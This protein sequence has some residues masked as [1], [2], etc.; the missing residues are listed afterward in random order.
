MRRLALVI[1]VALLA[2]GVW[3]V[4]FHDPLAGLQPVR[5]ERETTASDIAVPSYPARSVDEYVGSAACRECHA[6][7]AAEYESH[8]MWH[9]TRAVSG[10]VEAAATGPESGFVFRGEQ[11]FV[12]NSDGE[13]VHHI[14]GRDKQ[15]E[16]LYDQSAHVSY[17]IGSGRRGRAFVLQQD[18]LLFQSPI[19]WYAGKDGWGLSPG[20]VASHRRFDRRLLDG[21]VNCHVGLVAGGSG[22]PDRF[23]SP[24]FIEEGVGC[25]RCHGPGAA[26][27]QWH[28]SQT[29]PTGPDPIVN[30][31]D[32]P[33]AEREAVCQQC[34][35]TGVER[36]VR[37]GR[38]EFDFRPGDRLSD[39]WMAF[40]LPGSGEGA[41][42][43]MAVSHVEELQTSRCWTEAAEPSDAPPVTIRTEFRRRTNGSASIAQNACNAME[44]RACHAVSRR[45]SVCSHNRTTPASP[46]TCRS[47][48]PTMCRTRPRPITGCCGI[49]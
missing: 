22:Q 26:H 23:A 5:N 8:P 29:A 41:G 1:V 34:H 18:D 2:G 35:L 12:E 10:P 25:E 44:N 21:C 4:F 36:V 13:A 39:V 47:W 46:A 32:L 31:V 19:T 3:L 45:H 30:P 42:K 17:E 20:Y 40:V 9:S 37:A 6:A 15:G 7:I 49:P 43:R 38:S 27:I 28:S 16:V 14:V 24:P 33:P 48:T 11:Y